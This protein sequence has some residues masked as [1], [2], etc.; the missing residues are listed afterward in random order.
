MVRSRFMVS[1]VMT[2]IARP[3]CP[4]VVLMLGA[5]WSAV[6]RAVRIVCRGGASHRWHEKGGDFAVPACRSGFVI[7]TSLV[8]VH[9]ARQASE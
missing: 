1:D 6:A 7:A 8:S 4:W 2:A 5:D 9:P 3:R